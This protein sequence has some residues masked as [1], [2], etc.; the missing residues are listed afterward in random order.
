M[1]KLIFLL[2]II[3]TCSLKAQ[4]LYE[5]LSREDLSFGSINRDDVGQEWFETYMFCEEGLINDMKVLKY[6]PRYHGFPTIDYSYI[7]IEEEKVYVLEIYNGNVENPFKRLLYDFTVSEGDKITEG[8]YTDFEVDS[9]YNFTLPNGNTRLRIDLSKNQNFKASWLYGLGD[10]ERGFIPYLGP[11]Q[12][13]TFVC[14]KMGNEVLLENTATNAMCD[15]STCLI[16]YPIFTTS[17]NGSIVSPTAKVEC[18]QDLNYYWDFGDGNF[19]TEIRPTHEYIE[20]GCYQISLGFYRDCYPD[21]LFHTRTVDICTNNAW[22]DQYVVESSQPNLISLSENTDIIY[23]SR[24]LLKTTDAGQTWTNIEIPQ[25]N[26]G[27]GERLIKEIK[28]YDELEGIMTCKTQFTQDPEH[29][30]IFITKDGGLNWTP[31]YTSIYDPTS[32]GLGENGLA[33]SN[34]RDEL[35]RSKDHGETWE[36]LTFIPNHIIND[37]FYV[38]ESSLYNTSR[39]SQRIFISKSDDQGTTWETYE[40]DSDCS[41][42]HF[43]EQGLV[44]ALFN[45][46]I[47]VSN[48]EGRTWVQKELDFPIRSFSFSSPSNGWV[49]SHDRSVYYTSDFFSSIDVTRCGSNSS[50]RDLRSYNDSTATAFSYVLQQNVP[51]WQ[52]INFNKNRIGF[53]DCLPSSA[54]NEISDISIAIYP[55]PAVNT[56][57]IETDF[58]RF[59]VKVYNIRGQEVIQLKNQKSFNVQYLQNGTYFMTVTNDSETRRTHG[60]F[61]VQR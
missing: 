6:S 29:A 21:T 37:F 11:L 48:D 49:M 13:S 52:K 56:L 33:W 16:P 40:V 28:F 57:N 61:I 3:F 34:I 51:S 47:Y 38:D 35:L 1:K 26:D 25:P 5:L 60:K 12:V 45:N 44:Y 20:K 7:Y 30:S 36:K 8:Y 41:S 24:L 55:N 46:S 22:E 23:E 27:V 32:L 2:L 54:K 19:S 50:I 9:I 14:A 43:F 31:S 53:N 39:S 58:D 18:E 59:E 15:E 4:T 42:F 10:I 17:I